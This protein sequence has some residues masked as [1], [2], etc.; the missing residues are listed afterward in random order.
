MVMLSDYAV[1]IAQ[2]HWGAAI[3]L[4][5]LLY[6]AMNARVINDE[7]QGM[8]VQEDRLWRAVARRRLAFHL[9]LTPDCVYKS[10]RWLNE[11]GII[12]I[13]QFPFQDSLKRQRK[14]IDHAWIDI[15]ALDIITRE[16]EEEVEL[17][18]SAHCKILE[19]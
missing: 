1:E 13:K 12:K 15:E 11:K 5:Q 4:S 3:V 9:G 8:I 18:W 10:L 19:S 2:R 17:R 7:V 6:Y 14:L 16:I